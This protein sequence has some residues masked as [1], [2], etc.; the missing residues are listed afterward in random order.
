MSTGPSDDEVNTELELAV[1]GYDRRDKYP[2]WSNA[3]MRVAYR[4]GWDDG[5]DALTSI[6][7]RMAEL[8]AHADQV[9]D[10]MLAAATPDETSRHANEYAGLKHALDALAPL[11]Y[12]AEELGS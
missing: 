3:S 8:R 12:T 4:A 2:E 9:H 5:R 1:M 7:E 10:R 11:V 6:R